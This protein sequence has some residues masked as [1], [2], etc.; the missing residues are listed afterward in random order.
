MHAATQILYVCVYLCVFV[1]RG[2]SVVV[3]QAEKAALMD[4]F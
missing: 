1:Y 2:S 4:G 3:W